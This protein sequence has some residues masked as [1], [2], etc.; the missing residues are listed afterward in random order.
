MATLVGCSGELPQP[1]VSNTLT[2]RQA[3]VLSFLWDFCAAHHYPPTIRQIAEH[4][5][6]TSPNGVLCHLMVLE[7]KGL[8]QRDPKTARGIRLVVNL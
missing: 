1:R 5:A 3:S 6:I 8:I 4:F 2:S 7:R